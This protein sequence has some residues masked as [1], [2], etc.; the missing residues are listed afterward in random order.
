[1]NT[2]SY[3][4][5][6]AFRCYLLPD[7]LIFAPQCFSHFITKCFR[8]GQTWAYRRT[9]QPVPKTEVQVWSK[10]WPFPNHAGQANGS[11]KE[12]K[13]ACFIL[14]QFE[15]TLHLPAKDC[16][17]QSQDACYPGKYLP[18]V[19]KRFCVASNLRSPSKKTSNCETPIGQ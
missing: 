3:N 12:E 7:N 11:S 1:M 6:I 4:S 9:Q 10:Y 8:T 5:T 17:D 16:K 13:P 19:I 14:T 2:T 18:F 15:R